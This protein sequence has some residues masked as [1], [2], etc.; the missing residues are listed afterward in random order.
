MAPVHRDHGESK[1]LR[2]PLDSK[3]LRGFL[4]TLQ[5]SLSL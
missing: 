3:A 4:G 5:Y 2:A 1:A